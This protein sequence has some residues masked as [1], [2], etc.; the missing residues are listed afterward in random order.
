VTTTCEAQ[1]FV[2]YRSDDQAHMKKRLAIVGTKRQEVSVQTEV[3]ECREVFGIG[4]HD[5]GA[6]K[7]RA[8]VTLEIVAVEIVQA[9][10]GTH[11]F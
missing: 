11:P 1:E 6:G 4:T 10:A 3:I 5:D 8:V 7:S 9:E 2:D